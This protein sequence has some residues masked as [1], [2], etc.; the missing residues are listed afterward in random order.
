MVFSGSYGYVVPFF[1]ILLKGIPGGLVILC[2]TL[3][4]AYL[5]WATYKLKMGAWWTTLVAYIVLG[6]SAVVTFCAST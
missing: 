2:I 5:A 6:V 1:G 3:L 4:F